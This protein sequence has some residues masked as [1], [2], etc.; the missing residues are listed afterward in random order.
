MK[1][2]YLLPL[3]LLMIACGSK[4]NTRTSRTTKTTTRTTSSATNSNAK[5]EQIISYAKSFEG[6]KYRYGG[7]SRS[8]MECSGLIFTAFKQAGFQLPRVSR[9][10]ATRGKAISLSQINPGDLLFF[11]TNKSRNVINHVGLI[12]S[13]SGGEISFIH[14]TTSRGV[15]VSK[16]TENYWRSA[17]VGARRVL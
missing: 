14:A 1:K 17:F 3:L 16:L 7:T 8:G 9:D 6:V 12:V 15:I 10:M 5:A 2:Y 13:N 4:Q 11:Q